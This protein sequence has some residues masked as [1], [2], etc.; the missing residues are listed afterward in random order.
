MTAHAIS[1][2][3]VTEPAT[4]R[5][6]TIALSIVFSM[7]LIADQLGG[8]VLDRMFESSSYNPV[9]GVLVTN[10]TSVIVGASGSRYS[11]DPNILGQNTYNAASDGQSGFYAAALLRAIPARKVRRVIY[12]FDPSD[13]LSGLANPN[14]RQMARY[15]PWSVRDPQMSDWISGNSTISRFKLFSGFYRYHSIGHKVVDQWLHPRWSNRGFEP[16]LETMLPTKEN[17]AGHYEGQPVPPAESGLL[18]LEAVRDSVLKHDAELI[19]VI[20]PAYGY[21]RAK[22][23][24]DEGA[25]A[26]MRH[27]FSGLKVCDL[28]GPSSSPMAAIYMDNNNFRDGAHMNQRGAKLYSSYLRDLIETKCNM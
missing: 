15:T 12:G 7:L 6:V 3:S 28:T 9:A 1:S 18:M 21:D 8:L 26:A 24:K 25:V 27:L 16:L 2:T 14:V 22:V 23:R 17:R 19:V 10:S 20:T 4:F 5:T 13:V 11:M